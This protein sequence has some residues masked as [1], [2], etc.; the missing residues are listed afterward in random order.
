MGN[1]VVEL[2]GIR[3]II[4]IVSQ[5]YPRKYYTLILNINDVKKGRQVVP[6]GSADRNCRKAN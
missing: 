2:I 5:E 3:I 1:A 6:S 4:G